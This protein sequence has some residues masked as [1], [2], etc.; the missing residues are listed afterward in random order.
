MKYLNYI[1]AFVAVVMLALCSACSSEEEDIDLSFDGVI[2]NKVLD[3]LV[4][5]T[6]EYVCIDEKSYRMDCDDYLNGTGE[7]EEVVGPWFVARSQES[8]RRWILS[9]GQL[10]IPM[11]FVRST[12]STTMDFA[13]AWDIYCKQSG[14]DKTIAV[15]RS[16]SVDK[17]KHTLNSEPNTEY[18]WL[19]SHYFIYNI[20][21]ADGKYLAVSH[22][23]PEQGPNDKGEIVYRERAHKENLL[24]I[25]VKK[26]NMKKFQVFENGED[27]TLWMIK[28]MRE[29]FGDT[30]DAY[31]Y[32]SEGKKGRIIDLV[33]LEYWTKRSYL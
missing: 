2:D 1:N 28:K 24:F 4:N 30:I 20:H 16:I 32:T 3:K 15:G 29:Y 12:G 26:P 11:G 8:G 6:S 22:D 9:K 19:H 14:Y 13:D 18:P 17:E 5:E 25:K 21:K 27:A 31:K 33:E 10:I 7:W 23:Y